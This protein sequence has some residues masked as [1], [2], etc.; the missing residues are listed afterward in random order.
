MRSLGWEPAKFRICWESQRIGET[1]VSDVNCPVST[2]VQFTDHS[3]AYVALRAKGLGKVVNDF[4]ADGA[5]PKSTNR[6]PSP[7]P[8]C[9][10]SPIFRPFYD[11]A[12][13]GRAE[14]HQ[15]ERSYSSV[16]PPG[17]ISTLGAQSANSSDAQ[18]FS[19][20]HSSNDSKTGDPQNRGEPI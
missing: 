5:R 18:A 17:T 20:C 15:P 6:R 19:S 4:V 1:N 12:K 13:R 2:F 3:A 11:R 16:R 9:P 7:L 14:I 8:F 10:N